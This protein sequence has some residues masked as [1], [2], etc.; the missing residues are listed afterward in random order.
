MMNRLLEFASPRVPRKENEGSPLSDFTDG[1]VTTQVGTERS[2]HSQGTDADAPKQSGGRIREKAANRPSGREQEG[3]EEEDRSG[4]DSDLDE[5][6]TEFDDSDVD[7]LFGETNP[8]TLL[9]L[10]E[11]F[12]RVPCNV[13]VVG[14][15]KSVPSICG[16]RAD[17]CKRHHTKRDKGGRQSVGFYARV[18]GPAP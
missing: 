11:E 2:V 10:T 13:K 15:S 14:G 12:C 1:D 16:R 4:V 7:S 6:L 5:Q 8:S 9:H 17:I 18:E 3:M